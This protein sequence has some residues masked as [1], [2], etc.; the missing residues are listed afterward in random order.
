MRLKDKIVFA[1]NGNPAKGF[2]INGCNGSIIHQNRNEVLIDEVLY[3]KA[4]SFSYL[5]Y[6]KI[7]RTSAKNVLGPFK[8]E[9]GTDCNYFYNSVIPP[10]YL[11]DS[12]I[13]KR[14]NISGKLEDTVTSFDNLG[15]SISLHSMADKDN[16]FFFEQQLRARSIGNKKNIIFIGDM[17]P[18]EDVHQTLFGKVH[19]VTYLINTFIALNLD[20]IHNNFS[21]S[22]IVFSLLIMGILILLVTCKY[23]LCRVENNYF[24]SEKN[25]RFKHPFVYINLFFEEI[26]TYLLLLI[27]P[28]YFH[29]FSALPNIFMVL[30]LQ[31]IL[32]KVI[33]KKYIEPL[34]ETN[35]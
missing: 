30:L 2:K 27:F 28:F 16:F 34:F 18:N 31:F 1:D 29:H 22:L 4:P 21:N 11:T 7:N 23:I 25:K 19:G 26:S 20:K 9:I 15:S 33:D 14:S 17:S 5:I 32:L 13:V 35:K 10:I 24:K 8:K 3:D 12:D 6:S